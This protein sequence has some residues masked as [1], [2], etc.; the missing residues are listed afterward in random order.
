MVVVDP[1]S[2]GN[3]IANGLV[4]P[5]PNLEGEMWLGYKGFYTV[6]EW[7]GEGVQLQGINLPMDVLFH[8]NLFGDFPVA[9]SKRAIC[10][11]HPYRFL[12][13]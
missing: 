9:Y 6:D 7:A 4:V 11:F 10:L 13:K 12:P 2:P 1:Q 5:V 8:E 3:H